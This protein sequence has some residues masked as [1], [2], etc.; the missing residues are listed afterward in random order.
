MVF[1]NSDCVLTNRPWFYIVEYIVLVTVKQKQEQVV[2]RPIEKFSSWRIPHKRGYQTSI[3]AG[4]DPDWRSSV[5]RD[6]RQN[7][8]AWYSGYS[9]FPLDAP[10]LLWEPSKV[11]DT[12]DPPGRVGENT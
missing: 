6:P 4:N 7:Q 10:S 3:H 11:L 5:N 8:K 9:L 2:N 12:T 1:A